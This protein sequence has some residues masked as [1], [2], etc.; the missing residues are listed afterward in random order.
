MKIGYARVSTTDQKLRSQI[1]ALE[2]AGCEKIY[3]E[4]ASGGKSDRIQLTKMIEQLR[5]GD[6]VVIYRMDRLA[7]SVKQMIELAELFS[8]KGVALISLSDSIDTTTANGKFVFTV[9]AALAEMERN[10]IRERTKEGLKAARARGRFGGRPKGLSKAAMTKAISCKALYLEGKHT[11]PQICD[12]VG[13]SRGTVYNYLRA[14]GVRI[15]R[16]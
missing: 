12:Q 13:V 15:K 5:K 7:R 14:L 8:E 4:K 2:G 10:I 9:F 3:K 1:D 16:G 6:Q 11:I